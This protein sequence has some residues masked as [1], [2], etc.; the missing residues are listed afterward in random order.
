M[1]TFSS[2]LISKRTKHR[3]I[4]GGQNYQ[5][6][7]RIVL[8]EGAVLTQDDVLLFAPI[9]ENQRVNKVKAYI[10][11]SLPTAQ[12]SIGYAQILG[13]DGQPLVVQRRGPFVS[14][15]FYTSPADDLDAFAAAAVLST[16]REVV[17]P[18]GGKLAGPVHLAAEVTV[19]GTVGVGGVEIY[20]GAEF[21]GEKM[22]P[23]GN[24]SGYTGG[25]NYLID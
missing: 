18:D 3:G 11:G 19:G 12:V 14:D 25:G 5:I 15:E 9:G 23:E 8:P 24:I 6:V 13:P 21:D 16:A 7:G 20:I 17:V 1:A 2:A 10:V 22:L 4:Y